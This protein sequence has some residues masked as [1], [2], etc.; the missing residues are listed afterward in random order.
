MLQDHLDL[1]VGLGKIDDKRLDRIR[2]RGLRQSI[3][4]V[5]YIRRLQSHRHSRVQTVSRQAVFV[6]MGRT[7]QRLGDGGQEILRLRCQRRETLQG[8]RTLERIDPEGTVRM[9]RL[10]WQGREIFVSEVRVLV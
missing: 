5:D 1:P 10:E 2:Q 3:Q 4:E 6:Q 8:N 9:V 7:R